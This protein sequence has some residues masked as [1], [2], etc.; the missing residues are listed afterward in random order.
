MD[1]NQ[2]D[3]I[4]QTNQI[5]QM[6]QTQMDQSFI[7]RAAVYAKNPAVTGIAGLILGLFVGLV[8][9]GWWLWPVQWYD[10]APSNLHPDYQ[11]WWMRM[12]IISYGA[13]GD[14][15]TAKAE[16]DALG[17][18]GPTVLADVQA[19][20]GSIDP[21][22]ITQ[23]SAAVSATLPT[24][25]P[26]KTSVPGVTPT[27]TVA[28]GGTKSGR[29]NLATLLIVMCVVTLLV[30]AA[31]VAYFVLQS[32]K[33]NAPLA[34]T[35]EIPAGEEVAPTEWTNYPAPTEQAPMVQ[36]MAS[37][38]GGDDLF[39]DSFSI[40]SP[41]GEFLGECGVGISEVIGVG[42]PK[43][44]TAFEVWLF[45]KNDIQTVTKV[46][47]SDHAFNDPTIRQKL[48]AKGEPFQAV[49]GGQTI[50]ETATLRLVA[51]VVDMAYGQG[52]MPENSF[53]DSLVLELAIWQKQ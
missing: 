3:Q 22:L 42:V 18:F 49:A 14:A 20:P 45:D 38:K 46:L 11:D 47:M 48:E 25:A 52:S 26:A 5:P 15:T 36:F 53:F 7:D 8:V 28:A 43:K 27:A 51:R 33:K 34:P 44:V 30:G 24:Q 37:Y 23:Y 10:A 19:K 35:S 41:S 29:S 17:E 21:N 40:D 50:L 39:D 1:Q 12:S 31:F 13:T 32:R 6:D 9:L 16:Y 4:P 2:M